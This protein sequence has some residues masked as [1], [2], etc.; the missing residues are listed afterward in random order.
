[1]TL[2]EILECLSS[3]TGL[4]APRAKMPYGAALVVACI[5]QFC[6]GTLLGREPGVPIEGV[7]MARKKMFFDGAKAVRE[8]GLPQTLVEQALERAVRWFYDNGY[9]R[10]NGVVVIPSG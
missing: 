2:R 7:R 1:M 9:V 6:M 10:R 3:L 5:D 8:L 4:P